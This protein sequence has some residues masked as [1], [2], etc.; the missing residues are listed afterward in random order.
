MSRQ[1]RL[2]ARR[3]SAMTR[4]DGS[5][6]A[7]AMLTDVGLILYNT[8]ARVALVAYRQYCA[9]IVQVMGPRSDLPQFCHRFP[10]RARCAWYMPP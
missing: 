5:R 4:L 7:R 1:G 6:N 2:D 10:V 8:Y 9:S 3:L